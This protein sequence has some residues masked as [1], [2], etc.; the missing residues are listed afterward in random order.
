MQGLVTLQP[1]FAL[2]YEMYRTKPLR[3]QCWND[4]L[5]ALPN[6]HLFILPL[7]YLNFSLLLKITH[8][9]CITQKTF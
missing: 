9:L 3:G 6:F 7:A 1:H 4:T 2:C 8:I 5:S